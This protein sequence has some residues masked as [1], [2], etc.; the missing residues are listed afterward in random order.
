MT[1]Y[2]PCLSGEGAVDL[3][4]IQGSCGRC[5]GRD[6][7]LP[8][9]HTVP[10]DL[11]VPKQS[12]YCLFFNV[13]YNFG[14]QP[15]HMLEFCWQFT[16]FLRRSAGCATCAQVEV[17]SAPAYLAAIFQ[18]HKLGSSQLPESPA[19]TPCMVIFCFLLFQI[20]DLILGFI[21]SSVVSL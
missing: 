3:T 12:L 5:W 1:L 16:L 11:I 15:S 9:P 14:L 2:S 21:H 7:I 4:V 13:L 17:G 18:P 20:I 6:C 19:P 10:R 8:G